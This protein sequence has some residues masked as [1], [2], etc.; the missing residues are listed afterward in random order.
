[1]ENH[2]FS[3]YANDNALDFRE[4]ID[5]LVAYLEKGQFDPFLR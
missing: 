3:L 1:V 2:S 4:D 5:N